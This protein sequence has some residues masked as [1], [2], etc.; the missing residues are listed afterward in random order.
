MGDRVCSFNYSLAVSVIIP[1][2]RLVYLGLIPNPAEQRI[3]QSQ[4]KR[5]CLL[6]GHGGVH[7]LDG[8]PEFG[9]LNRTGFQIAFTQV[10][11]VACRVQIPY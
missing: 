8:Q 5:D 9:L 1:S 6:S 7:S 4:G 3:S 11:L 10:L 2:C